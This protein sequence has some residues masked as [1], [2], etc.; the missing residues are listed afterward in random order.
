M[1]LTMVGEMGNMVNF[2]DKCVK[3]PRL[4]RVHAR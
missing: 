4:A 3:S 2:R 1:M